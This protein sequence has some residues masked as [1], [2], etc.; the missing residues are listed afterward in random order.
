VN[1]PTE[2]ELAALVDGELAESRAHAVRDHAGACVPCRRAVAQ[3]EQVTGLLRAPVAG[4]LGRHSSESFADLVLGQLDRPRAKRARKWPWVA[5][6]AAATTIAAAAALV[7]LFVGRPRGPAEEWAARGSPP[8]A[9]AGESVR[10][11]LLRF[12]RISGDRFDAITPGATIY[13]NEVVAAEVGRTGRRPLFLLAFV[14]DAEGERH[15][16]YPAYEVGAPPPSAEPL[17]AADVP[18]VLSTMTRLSGPA[19][20]PARL[21]AIV[22]TKPASVEPIET[23]PLE[24]LS[25]EKLASHFPNALVT[26][27]RVVVG[28]P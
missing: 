3:L 24:D 22:L 6:L 14:V 5:G 12:G 25:R 2:P 27:T 9:P 19:A 1:C 21:V 16:I 10:H 4:A 26:E 23:A 13:P 15:W 20:G 18:R 28:G 11:V 7:A 8:G 17:P